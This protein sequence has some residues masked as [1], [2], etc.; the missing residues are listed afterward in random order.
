MTWLL[1]KDYRHNRV[2]VIAGVVLLLLPY[3]FC[4]VTAWF[5]RTAGHPGVWW[6]AMIAG[7]G[8]YSLGL[9]QVTVALLGGNAIAGE[10][11]DR[12]AEFLV[13]LPI[14]RRKILASK[15]LLTLIIVAV[16]WINALVSWCLMKT[17]VEL[18]KLFYDEQIY[19]AVVNIATVGS[20]FFCVGW[21]FSS[22]LN[23]PTFAVAAAL[24]TPLL[25][26]SGMV[27]IGRFFELPLGNIAFVRWFVGICLTLA[28]VCFS[29]GT[30]YYYL[31]RVEP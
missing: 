31:R 9:S 22:F 26:A 24:I 21:L 30:W 3:T 19:I 20:V 5:T 23:S 7:A 12:S 28:L 13:S 16:I 29:A 27:F 2:L 4:L 1:W 25:V 6:T 11:V 10:R 14:S 15:L 17:W 8:L 18:E